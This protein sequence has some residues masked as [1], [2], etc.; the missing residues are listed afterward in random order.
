MWHSQEDH[1]EDR[2]CSMAVGSHKIIISPAITF[3]KLRYNPLF[4]WMFSQVFCNFMGR[5]VNI[6]FI[7]VSLDLEEC[8][9]QNT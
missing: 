2:F 5:D 6:E 3:I 1:L 4:N 8:L 7:I 9:A